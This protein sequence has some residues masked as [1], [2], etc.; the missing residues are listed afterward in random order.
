LK[1]T[2]AIRPSKITKITKIIAGSAHPNTS[3]DTLEG[4]QFREPIAMPVIVQELV[5]ISYEQYSGS[6]AKELREAP[7]PGLSISDD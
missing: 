7:E 4:V 2:H 3:H 1:I 6:L 5:D